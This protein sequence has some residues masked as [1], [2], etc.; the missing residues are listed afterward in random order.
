AALEL[1][2]LLDEPRVVRGPERSV[3]R[4]LQTRGRACLINDERRHMTGVGEREVESDRIEYSVKHCGHLTRIHLP[5]ETLETPQHF[6]RARLQSIG[7]QVVSDLRHGGG[8]R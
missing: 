6:C 5:H 4:D 2:L 8:S 1:L 7:A 3:R